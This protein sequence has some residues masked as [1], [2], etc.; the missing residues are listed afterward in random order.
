[1][2][3][4]K[5]ALEEIKGEVYRVVFRSQDNG[6]T[7]FHLQIPDEGF[8]GK[9][10][11]CVGHLQV[12]REG[13]TYL[14]AGTWEQSQKHGK[15]FRFESAEL[16]LPS[17]TDGAAR[18][19]SQIVPGVGIAKAKAIVQELGED[20]LEKIKADPSALDRLTCINS[21]QRQAIYQHL[22]TN[23][24]QA[25]LAGMIVGDGIGM[26]M[27][28]RIMAKYGAE[29]VK[30]VKENPYVLSDDIWGVGFKKADKIALTIGVQP[31]SPHRVMAAV[32]YTLKQSGEDGHTYL[33]PNLIIHKL[34]G[35]K[36]LIEASGVRVQDIAE[37]NARL[38]REERCIREGNYI[39]SLD[40]YKAEVGT[41]AAIR[42]KLQEA[43]IDIPD[44][45]MRIAQIEAEYR[46]QFPGFEQFAPEQREAVK[47]AL[48]QP[49]SIITGGP[50]TGKTTVQRAICDIYADLM[51]KLWLDKQLYM[52]APTGRASKRMREATGY[53]CPKTIH[54]LLGYR[55]G[56]GFDHH[57]SNPLP[58]P[59][60]LIVDESSMM[61][62]ELA[63]SLLQA[64][65][66][67]QVILVGDVD[68]LPSVGPG[69]VLRDCIDSGLIPTVRLNYNYRQA[70][71]SKIAEFAAMVRDG[72]CPPLESSGDFRFFPRGTDDEA[73]EKIS[74]MIKSIKSDG[75]SLM[76]WQVLAPMHKSAAGVGHL[77]QVAREIWNPKG[78]EGAGGYRVGDKV[79]V[80][81][82]NRE[83]E[84]FN[85]DIGIVTEVG[86]A[87]LTA[88][89]DGASVDFTFEGETMKLLTLAYAST[90]HKAQGSEFPLVIM[91]LVRQHFMMLQRNLL[92]TGMT[93]AK[94]RLCLVGDEWSIKHAISNDA[95]AER[96]TRL[97]ERIR[98]EV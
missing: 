69:N 20:A 83:L 93:R 10:V 62:I 19:L 8:A 18:Y 85:G 72:V 92:Y 17:G 15:Q 64:S 23:N 36:G 74:S 21:V 89:I 38:I 94:K 16:Q 35:R 41:A 32:D 13:E 58:G 63:H 14:L 24:V 90:I 76:N 6:Y 50:G 91:P 42:D 28:G 3:N 53:D 60:L 86:K 39:Y 2:E 71:G 55:P 43:V 66:K 59:G 65:G 81:R 97:K 27:V 61:D 51:P 29:A 77:N 22:V 54:R 4:P 82:N 46:R 34:I 56:Y 95:I 1:M 30:A 33:R 25:E 44:L 48:T 5:P 45:D 84:V 31:N 37:A 73:S 49:I 96:Y 75:W 12:V 67:L 26:G 68:Q 9:I 7:V 88:D 11:T 70:G 47:T 87:G 57:I 40:L 79:M 52:C 78:K 80:I 98:G